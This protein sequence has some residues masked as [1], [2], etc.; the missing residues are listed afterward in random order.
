[1]SNYDEKTGI[2]YGVISPNSISQ[3]SL[4]DLFTSST[5]PYYESSKSEFI[6]SL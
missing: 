4:S 5:D 3:E 1:M 2:S 6:D